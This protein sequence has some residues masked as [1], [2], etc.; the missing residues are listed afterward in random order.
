MKAPRIAIEQ[1][2]SKLMLKLIN[3]AGDGWL[4]NAKLS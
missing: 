1:D 2:H 3:P 4:S